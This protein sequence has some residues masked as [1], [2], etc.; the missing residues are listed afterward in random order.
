MISRDNKPPF[1]PLFDLPRLF[2]DPTFLHNVNFAY[3]RDATWIRAVDYDL[4]G[5]HRRFDLIVSWGN[6]DKSFVMLFDQSLDLDSIDI[7]GRWLHKILKD[8]GTGVC[9]NSFVDKEFIEKD[10]Q[11]LLSLLQE[12]GII[13]TEKLFF[14]KRRESRGILEQ[15]F[16][17]ILLKRAQDWISILDVEC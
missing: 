13:A 11:L 17:D 3:N 14:R 9:Q 4:L 12:F 2:V 16:H 6:R 1:F 10:H 15:L 7:F 5:T 8:W